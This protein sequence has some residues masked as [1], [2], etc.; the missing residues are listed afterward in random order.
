MKATFKRYMLYTLYIH[1]LSTRT[2]QL[3][4]PAS[5]RVERGSVH[6][7]DKNYLLKNLKK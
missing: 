4:P 6:S 1:R 2:L 7:A 3:P 5:A